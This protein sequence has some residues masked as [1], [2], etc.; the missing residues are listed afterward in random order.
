[1]APELEVQHVG[2]AHL[3]CLT[4]RQYSTNTTSHVCYL[5]HP[6][7]KLSMPY[8]K[9]VVIKRGGGDG[10]EFPLTATC[11][12]GRKPDCDIR[13]QLPHVS[14]EHCRVEL[15]ENKE[16]ILTNMSSMNP[17]R[18]NGEVLQQAER[19]KHGDVITIIDRSFR[20]EHPPQRTPK[21]SSVSG[22]T[23]TPQVLHEQVRTPG[24]NRT[25]EISTGPRLKDGANND[26]I[27]R[28]LEKA[29]DV[30]SSE[31]SKTD[32]PFQ[33]LYQMIKNSLETPR[34]PAGHQPQ[35]PATVN[36]TP[37]PQPGLIT[38]VVVQAAASAEAVSTP[39]KDNTKSQ[40]VVTAKSPRKCRKSLDA[41][42]T[43]V[44]EK[45]SKQQTPIQATKTP[46][47]VEVS[48]TPKK[49]SPQKVSVS[50]VVV[51]EQQVAVE[52]PK[53]PTR[54]KS[55]EATSVKP[56]AE[57]Q[58]D[59]TKAA[60]STPTAAAPV[61]PSPRVSPRSVEKKL[62]AQQV[63]EELEA[64]A[65]A[66]DIIV[67]KQREMEAAA[68]PRI[69]RKRV[70]F[71]GH[72]SPE[73]FDKRLPPSSPLQKGA[74]PR[75]SLSAATPKQ[76][77]LRRASTIGL[78]KEFDEVKS[79]KAKSPAKK[80]PKA[81]TPSPA[82]KSPKANTPSPAKKSPK[83]KSDTPQT[84][85]QPQTPSMPASSNKKRRPSAV[86]SMPTNDQTSTVNGRFSISRINTP[87]PV[88]EQATATP[89]VPLR[90]KSMKSVS[91]KTP[92]RVLKNTIEV[93]RRRSGVSRASMKVVN[94]WVDIVKFGQSKSQVVAPA[95]KPAA[96]QKVKKSVVAVP[97][98]PAKMSLMG[99]VTTGH[100]DSPV[101][102]VVGK[103]FHQRAVQPTGA[104][105]K[106]VH[107]IALLK[108]NMKMDEDLTGISEIFS[109]PVN[110]RKR[111]STM[112]LET[113]SQTPPGA[114]STSLVEM[115]TMKTP[116]ETGEMVV[117]P[118]GVVSTTKRMFNSE[119]VQRLLQS[120]EGSSFNSEAPVLDVP[121]EAS[122]QDVNTKE[123]T[124]KQKPTEKILRTPK[125]K[126]E[127]IEDLR[128][129]LLKT[130]KQKPQQPD[131]LS[132]VKRIMKTPRQ[133]CEPIEDLRGKLLK[134]PR[135]QKVYGEV[136]L[137]G[138]KQLLET[139]KQRE[140]PVCVVSE[141]PV[142]EETF[143]TPEETIALVEEVMV[144]ETLATPEETIAPVEEVMVEETLA[145]PEEIIA[146][147]EEVVVEETFAPVKVVLE[148]TL[149]TPE[150]TIVPN[151]E[152][153]VEETLATPE[154]TS[155]LIQE[156][157]VAET[158]VTPEETIPP[159]EEVMVEDTIAPI[160]EAV[161]EETPMA[162]SKENIA[163]VEEVLVEETPA[164]PEKSVAPVEE[165]VI[166]ETVAD[167]P[168]EN[169]E[170]RKLTFSYLSLIE[171]VSNDAP[172]E[173]PEPVVAMEAAPQEVAEQSLP[174]PMPE[175]ET[176]IPAEQDTA[177]PA[178]KPP[179]KS[180]RGKRAKITKPA[181][182]E[183]PTQEE[184]TA[185]VRGRRGKQKQNTSV[186]PQAEEQTPGTR[187]GRPKKSKNVE[188]PLITS[189][190]DVAQEE[191][192]LKPRRG[193]NGK[194]A[195]AVEAVPE[196][197]TTEE[198][199]D[200]APPT[201]AVQSDTTAIPAVPSVKTQTRRGRNSKQVPEQPTPTEPQ[202][203]EEP[204][205]AVQV[206]K[207]RRG[208]KAAQQEPQVAVVQEESSEVV[209]DQSPSTG[210]QP[211]EPAPVIVKPR[212]GRKA[213]PEAAPEP[214]VVVVEQV[215]TEEQTQAPVRAKRGR[216]ATVKPEKVE[217]EVELAG[218]AEVVEQTTTAPAEKPK[219]GRRP[220]KA[221][222][223]EMVVP[224]T[225]AQDKPTDKPKRGGRRAKA[226]QVVVE[227]VTEL[228]E[229]K[230][231]SEQAE[232]QEEEITESASTVSVEQPEKVVKST[233]GKRAAVTLP[234]V[235]PVKRG[236]RGAIEPPHEA[237]VVE[238]V[239][240]P[241]S[242][243]GARGRAGKR[244]TVEIADIPV[245]VPA[246]PAT[247]GRKK[248]GIT[249]S[250]TTP[251]ETPKETTV[252]KVEPKKGRVTKK[253]KSTPKDQESLT[254]V[255]D[256]TK[257]KSVNWKEDLTDI[258]E[259]P[260]PTPVLKATRGR[261][262]AV[263]SASRT[264]APKIVA[265]RKASRGQSKPEEEDLSEISQPEVADIP[266][267]VPA[268]PAT[269]GRKKAGIP[270]STTTRVET[271]EETAAD[272]TVTR[273][274]PTPTPVLKATRGRKAAVAPARETAAPKVVAKRKVSRVQSKAEEEDLSEVSL[275]KRTRK[276]TKI[277]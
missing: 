238:E 73:L 216:A 273:E 106:M 169:T 274:I 123:A 177:L 57:E 40:V 38:K 194:Q 256:K 96:I 103:A 267:E 70:S 122:C 110:A 48:A 79:L 63:Q 270:V 101:T 49:G 72:L 193:R 37:K 112:L 2:A 26:N 157:V 4:A 35:T 247:K 107:N 161:V 6:R 42:T 104:A 239:A 61:K 84:K 224:P 56:T 195:P 146:P 7:G 208:R 137:D 17:T 86:V 127:P 143:T 71:G 234:P 172:V 102:I 178:P 251:V 257:S 199:N 149:A 209:A 81:K 223:S 132:G 236:R 39:G 222:E 150:E 235:T 159:I 50:E 115:S 46:T 116:E 30:E 214:E 125:Q 227:T 13:I 173:E 220:T 36:R 58:P 51:V 28:S 138:V 185:P 160:E 187:H 200:Q 211:E 41:T 89:K 244:S 92:K 192:S 188:E 191:T 231:E 114:L 14:K 268:G 21:K 131:C 176:L 258:H 243:P 212:R 266:V 15:N 78:I 134:T 263:A 259:I 5:S 65:A 25:S 27:Q 11:L 33:E 197:T 23:D 226:E 174:E 108:K 210:T 66:R 43:P 182:D 246:E 250:T 9:I 271:P 206:E 113:P 117:S 45:T 175:E 139:P 74:T 145:T 162:T 171:L 154:E 242:Q 196:T 95:K 248:A 260:T 68:S 203:E 76:S 19:L 29:V 147:V 80:S 233:R 155:C 164:N 275:V 53:T 156:V 83:A 111:K 204:V 87:S 148:E 16:V 97:K 98:T 262:A 90:R 55:K 82:K 105:P 135:V 54:R 221:G 121:V 52:K 8:G 142:V 205:P 69:M 261:K 12:F 168:T 198:T 3:T 186:P 133:K 75:R 189:L 276:V 128:G 269:K 230:V 252:E 167:K 183:E 32:S 88:T 218:A 140:E 144:E 184:P 277:L 62:K 126:A 265:K 180:V 44:V 34:K 228:P 151:K 264:A 179:T 181:A 219:R 1:M 99:H 240:P 232:V 85:N 109:T 93:L 31:E 64:N 119:A 20:F 237:A 170:V 124:P 141:V 217:E 163:P 207:P 158:L 118:L 59:Q 166:E 165:V 249:V 47:T 100:A 130:P 254:T 60:C 253:T 10:T 77:L 22:K 255:E 152:V 18:I 272:L 201:D 94:S 136:N 129:K 215:N 24:E 229:E 67:A 225:E 213:N 120:E 190:A 153:V 202:P 91:R 245:E 241:V